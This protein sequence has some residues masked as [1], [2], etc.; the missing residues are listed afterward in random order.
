MFKRRKYKLKFKKEYQY[1]KWGTWKQVTDAYLMYILLELQK[2]YNFEIVYI[3]FKD[4]FY[5]SCIKI[6]CNKGDKYK[7]FNEYCA[8]LNKQ[9]TEVS[10]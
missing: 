4:C 1:V 7:I 2:K 5:N 10:F 9:I 3:K 8:I 6:R